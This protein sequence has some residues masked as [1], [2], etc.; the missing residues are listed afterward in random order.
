MDD[1]VQAMGGTG[2]SRSRVGRLCEEIDERVDA[3]LAR[4][5]EGERPYLRIDATYLKVREG[6]RIV[7][8]AATIAVGADTDG[9]RE[10]LGLSIGASEAFGGVEA[11]RAS[12]SIR[13]TL[14]DRAPP[15]PR[16]ARPVGREARDLVRRGNGPP[17]RFP[18][19]LTP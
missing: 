9:R 7:D 15:Q 10:V 12:P 11:R 19:L 18:I 13:L 1:P 16:A 17:D 14:L 5:I 4:P 3:F 6:G 8:V 2:V